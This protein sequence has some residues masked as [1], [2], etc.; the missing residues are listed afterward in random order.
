MYY[1][2]QVNN[3]IDGYVVEVFIPNDNSLRGYWFPL[4]NFGD[5]QGDAIAFRDWDCPKLTDLQI[6]ALINRYDRAVKYERVSASKFV[7]Q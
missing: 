4:R 1:Q 2:F 6:K 7:K 5:R 3:T